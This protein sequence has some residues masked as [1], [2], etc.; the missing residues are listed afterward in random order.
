MLGGF[1]NDAAV[2]LT[3]WWHQPLYQC[4]WDVTKL[5]VGIFAAAEIAKYLL[6]FM[7]GRKSRMVRIIEGLEDDLKHKNAELARLKAENGTLDGELKAAR[8]CLPDAAIARAEREWR[9][10]NQE[11]AS[12]ELQN[13]FDAN[14][15]GIARIAT[16]L[17]EFHISRGA[18][19]R[20]SPG[21]G[22]Q[23]AAARARGNA[24]QSRSARFGKRTRY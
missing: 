14:A 10:N 5:A 8:D 19:P 18:R 11:R 16:K 9:Y 2:A 24:G 22:P 6:R 1:I 15:A 21:Y 17:A 4:A 3:E 20:R 13:W 12:R 7:F 23:Y